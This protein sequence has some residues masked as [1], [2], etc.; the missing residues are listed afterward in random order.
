MTFAEST[1]RWQRWLLA[2]MLFGTAVIILP[3]AVE[4]FM[5]P[6]ATFVVFL[7]V[8]LAALG[9]ASALWTRTI[10][11][12]QSPVTVAVGIFT[13]ALA[14]TTITSPT[15]LASV[16]GFYSRYTG[17]VPYL[18][19]LL[20]FFL[21]LRLADARLV[22]LL[23]RTAL[24][25]LGFVVAYGLA[26]AAGIDP[27]AY[28]DASLGTTFSFLGNV[29]FSAAWAGAVAALA[30]VTALSP[31]EPPGWR[32]Y[33]AVLTPLTV[34]YAVLTGTAQGP[35][36]AA[37]SLGWVVLLLATAS[38]SRV[39]RAATGRRG[40]ALAVA[41]TVA[42]T[43][44]VALVVAL[45][46][47]RAQLEQSFVER[48]EFWA[49]AVGIFADHPVIGTGL[50]TYAHHF[51]AYRPASHALANGTATT[52]APHSVLLG[53]LS[54][55]GLLL[56][57][58][59]VA[60]VALVAVA[61]VKGALHSQGAPRLALAG[62]GGVWLGYQAQSLVSFDVPP[63]ALL[64][65]LSAGVIVALAAP[66]RWKEITLPG[67]AAAR[68]INHR[69]GKAYGAVAVPPS[70]RVLQG[71]VG[72]LAL[73]SLWLAAYPLRADL[74]AASAAPLTASGKFDEAV[75][76]FR[77]AAELN[78]AESSYSFLVARAEDAAGRPQRALAA[79]TE[80]ARR[81]PG[82]VQYALFAAEQAQETERE[83][84]AQRWYRNAVER[85]PKDPPVLNAAGAYLAQTGDLRAAEALLERSARLRAEPDTLVLLGRARAAMNDVA[86]AREVL[87]QALALDRDNAD[88]RALLDGLR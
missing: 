2:A 3:P 32:L 30:L 7:A 41:G 15:P 10:A 77:R 58:A 42:V 37:V 79:A 87:E 13:L 52:D 5:L 27:I 46:Y 53:M 64:H 62:F 29:N 25:A 51:M 43:A 88:A 11:V 20:V 75:E 18:A 60:A 45:P 44:G 56:G 40:L 1:L 35:V 17:L 68:R 16:I 48:P 26:Q 78:P 19:Y 74:V 8:V 72:V 50:D 83:Q 23:R 54:N 14:I 71:A 55:G 38:D 57:S 9:A 59:Y 84:V 12:P 70:T 82:T 36:V 47:L 85:D 49:A 4:P 76:R 80:A 34:L 65:W 31:G 39:R 6:K 28:S 22:R 33:A 73:A 86:G 67:P 24:V 69:K 21:V 61:L 66:P 81:D 63:L